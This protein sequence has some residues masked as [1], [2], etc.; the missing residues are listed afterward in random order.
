MG[1]WLGLG[2]LTTRNGREMKVGKDN[3]DVNDRV[4]STGLRRK[5]TLNVSFCVKK[6]RNAS[7]KK[8][9]FK[10]IIYIQ[11]GFSNFLK[12]LW[13]IKF[14]QKIVQALTRLVAGNFKELFGSLLCWSIN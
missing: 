3:M 7:F 10:I 4:K 5:A 6:E 13:S 8:V 14:E 1:K 2:Q 11:T 12:L 9:C